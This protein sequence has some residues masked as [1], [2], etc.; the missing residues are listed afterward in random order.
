[1]QEQAA[2]AGDGEVLEELLEPML[3]QEQYQQAEQLVREA[4]DRGSPHRPTSPGSFADAW[5]ARP[6]RRSA[7]MP[8]S[9][10]AVIREILA[11]LRRRPA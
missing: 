7:G 2:L 1:M 3:E 6:R 10:G 5:T 4:A 8:R 9:P 11:R